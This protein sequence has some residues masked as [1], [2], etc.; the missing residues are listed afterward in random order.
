MK[1][2][3]S[4]IFIFTF[5]FLFSQNSEE[6]L[7]NLSEIK[8]CELTFTDL[9]NQ[10]E[11]LKEVEVVEMDLCSD[12]FVSD[13]KFVNRKGYSS[14]YFPGIIFQK[15]DDRDLIAKIRLTKDFKGNLPD[16]T[17]VNLKTLTAKE[18]L[19]KYPTFNTWNSKGCSDYWSLTNKELYFYVEIDKS[20]EPRYPIDEKYY[21]TKSIQ[22]IDIVAN[23]Y[24]IT[25]KNNSINDVLFIIDDKIVTKEEVEKYDPN[26]I[27]NVTVLKEKAATEKYGEKGKNG[28][29]IIVTKKYL[30]IN[31]K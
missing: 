24:E 25:K 29:I 21:L 16:G 2:T 14:K 15:Y 12:G 9:K 17:Y 20:K 13:S 5:S 30:E 22:G 26:D 1:T 8:L 7:I 18:V 28:V 27:D 31:K 3:F 6:K 19:E 4:L 11:N 23:C 10:D